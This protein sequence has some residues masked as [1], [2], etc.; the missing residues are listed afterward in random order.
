[1]LLFGQLTMDWE[2]LMT[3]AVTASRPAVR[4]PFRVL[5]ALLCL[6]FIG[7]AV[8][9]ATMIWK[10]GL[11]A[12]RVQDVLLL[13]GMLWFLRLAFYAAARGTVPPQDNWPFATRGVAGVYWLIFL[14]VSAAAP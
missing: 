2:L 10:G 9:M 13:P 8:G 3:T 14:C 7:A 12:L 4:T 5:A 1:M 6:S 11:Q